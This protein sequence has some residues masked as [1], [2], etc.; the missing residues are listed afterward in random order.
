MADINQTYILCRILILGVGSENV[1]TFLGK[2]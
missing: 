2:L 1:L